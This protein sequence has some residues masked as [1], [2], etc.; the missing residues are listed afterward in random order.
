M[1]YDKIYQEFYTKHYDETVNAIKC[2]FI[3]C[4]KYELTIS[5]PIDKSNQ[6][7]GTDYTGGSCN[8]YSNES[9]KKL[10]GLFV[11]CKRKYTKNSI[12]N[13][14]TNNIKPEF[15]NIKIAELPANY[16]FDNLIDDIALIEAKNEISRLL[17][18]NSMLIGMFFKFGEFD[19]FEI[20]DIGNI[21][22]QNYPLF[23][24]F[25]KRVYPEFY[26]NLISLKEKNNPIYI[27]QP[28]NEK[29]KNYKNEIWFKTGI[30][31][32]TGEA[33]N[34]YTKYKNDKGHFTKLCLELGF[35]KTDR[36]YFSA[37]LQNNNGD[38]NTFA[39]KDKLQKLHKHLTENELNFGVEFLIEYKKLELE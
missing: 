16:M 32:A 21:D 14:L 30:T 8:T 5:E 2:F 11:N 29:T 23:I 37:T 15:D 36:P 31:L 25:N 3:D 9:L 28:T 38:K 7:L 19:E 34:L 13:S 33:F 17:S 6:F 27:E 39:S 1:N 4:H 22:M 18:Q 26:E 12:Q 24:K 10:H 35:K 20:R